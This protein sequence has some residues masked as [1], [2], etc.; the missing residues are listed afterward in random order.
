MRKE[1]MNRK[2][3]WLRENIIV[4]VG[5]KCIHHLYYFFRSQA[6]VNFFFYILSLQVVSKKLGAA[7]LKKGHVI[8]LRGNYTAR[9]KLDDGW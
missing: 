4:K 2:D 1:K 7:Y 5:K 3:Y 8:G 9:L 6:E